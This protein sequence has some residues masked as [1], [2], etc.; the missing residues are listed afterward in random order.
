MIFAGFL[1]ITTN[2]LCRTK[3][4]VRNTRRTMKERIMTGYTAFLYFLGR[5]IYHVRRAEV[6]SDLTTWTKAHCIVCSWAIYS[7][8]YSEATVDQS[9]ECNFLKIPKR[10]L[11]VF[12]FT[13]RN[14]YRLR[15]T[16][17]FH[18]KTKDSH[19]FFATFT[20]ANNSWRTGYAQASETN[21][22]MPLSST[23]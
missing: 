22:S 19:Y 1:H 9:W 11:V 23:Q 18:V 5:S 15:M 14:N 10:C 17:R 21:W 2:D 6:L 3:T 8:R 4:D 12:S 16:L 7:V 13:A 20:C